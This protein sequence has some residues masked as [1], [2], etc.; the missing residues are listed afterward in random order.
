MIVMM[1]TT[2]QQGEQLAARGRVAEALHIL[3]PAAAGG[4][5][6]ALFL[7]AVWR[8]SGEYLPRDLAAS[9]SLFAKAAQVGRP[10]AMAI[11]AAFLANGT[12]GNVDWQ[13]ALA[14]LHQQ[15]STDAAAA[16]QL[17]I[18]DA[19]WLSSDGMPLSVPAAGMVSASPL[20]YRLPAL[21]SDAEC[22]FL[23][24]SATPWLQPAMVVDPRTGH[25]VR[26]PVR[27][28]DGAAFPLAMENPAIHALNR[29]I[30]AASGTGVAQG[31]PLQILSYRQGQQ[32]RPHVDA[33]GHTDNER[34][35]TM[36][37][38]LNDGY[39]GGETLFTAIGLAVKGPKGD[40]ILFRNVDGMGRADMLSR[41]AG[42]PVTSGQK[43][44]ASRWIRQYPLALR[45]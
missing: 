22:D 27:T 31:E 24:R 39:E 38:Y 20:I 28:S 44:L 14:I 9:R 33:I 45:G 2:A 26:D 8:L 43:F 19:M 11:H 36:L 18:I 5:P 30:A 29:R 16:D 21:L 6:D 15:A 13:Q 17:A 42:L 7:L 3:E 40:A 1:M 23:I 32:Y 34:I 35:W 41:H 10:D 25:Y 37:V 4:D 12:G